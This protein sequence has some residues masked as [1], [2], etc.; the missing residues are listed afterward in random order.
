MSDLPPHN[1][2]YVRWADLNAHADREAQSRHDLAD[3]V[4]SG[5]AEMRVDLYGRLGKLDE[6]TDKLESALDQLRGARV[7][8]NVIFGTS[9]IGA[10]AGVISLIVALR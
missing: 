1:G 3:R 7:I 8:L 6:R 5:M 9:I 2:G 10:L 4:N